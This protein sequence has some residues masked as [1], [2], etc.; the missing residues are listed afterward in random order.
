MLL[1]TKPV[2]MYTFRV[3]PNRQRLGGWHFKWTLRLVFGVWCLVSTLAPVVCP[4]AE[5]G[6]NNLKCTHYEHHFKMRHF[7]I[8]SALVK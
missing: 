2:I 3:C 6:S 8:S 4:P 5:I 7:V 1:F